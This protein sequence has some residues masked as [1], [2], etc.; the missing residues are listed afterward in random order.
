MLETF[1]AKVVLPDPLV[2]TITILFEFSDFMTSSYLVR[3]E[4]PE[5]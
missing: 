2:P 3:F 4:T 5:N 1:F